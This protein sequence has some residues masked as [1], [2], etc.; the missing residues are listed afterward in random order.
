MSK[1]PKVVGFKEISFWQEDG[2]GVIAMLTGDDGKV[3]MNF[4]DEFLRA[5]TLA[6]TDEKVRSLV[7]TGTNDT[8]FKGVRDLSNSTIRTYLE[9][10]SATASFLST[11]DKPVISI[12]N[13]NA[14]DLGVELALLSDVII[15]KKGTLLEVSGNYEPVMG[16]SISALKYS[17]FKNGEAEEKSNCDII[18]EG[19]DFLEK[20]SDYIKKLGNPGL[21]LIRRNRLKDIRNALSIEREYFLL[22]SL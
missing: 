9:L 6:I 22:K 17:F 18:M 14:E 3:T 7:I 2:I 20:A 15:A 1:A 4:F 13:G 10:T 5:I 11:M 8:F 16:F 12:V 21:N 19:E